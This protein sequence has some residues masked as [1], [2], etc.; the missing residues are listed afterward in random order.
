MLQGRGRHS[1]CMCHQTSTQVPAPLEMLSSPGSPRGVIFFQLPCF[2]ADLSF[3]EISVVGSTVTALWEAPV[4]GD[5]SCF[6][7]Q[8]LPEPPKPGVCI[9]QEFSAN[10]IRQETG[11]GAPQAPRCPPT[12]GQG[13]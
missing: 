10:S 12:R 5:A 9:P 4:P 1:S 2:I 7:Q 6:E 8:T 3:K 13:V 11:K